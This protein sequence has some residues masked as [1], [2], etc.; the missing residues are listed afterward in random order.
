MQMMNERNFGE[1]VSGYL[2]EYMKDVESAHGTESREYLALKRQFVFDPREEIVDY[3]TERRRH[4]EAE[5]H[6]E[7]EGGPLRGLE[8][9]YQK[10][11]LIEPTTHCLAYCRWCLRAKYPDAKLTREELLRA[12]RYCG[13][14]VNRADVREIL[15]T[16][17]DPLIESDTIG[18]MLDAIAEFAPNVEAVRIGSRLPIH[19]PR[20]VDDGLLEAL[21]PRGKFRVEMGTQINHAVELGK[22]TCSAYERIQSLGI[23][24]YNQ[25]VLLR[26]VNDDIDS[27]CD[28]YN[29]LRSLAIEAHY[30]FHCIPMRGMSHHRTTLE[31]G[32]E[33]VKELVMCG[34][35]SGRAKPMY[36]AMTDVGKVILYD[37]VILDRKGDMVL[38]QTGYSNEER[39]R[40][41]PSW[42]LPDSAY[43]GEDEKIR[44]WYQDAKVHN[45]GWPTTC[46]ID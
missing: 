44:V 22:E 6:I 39:S 19:D 43:V 29:A 4:Y 27:L 42:R 25:Q 2:R 1:R 26:G 20:R 24:V 38:L 3:E 7:F 5:I 14:A 33:L 12:V 31:R 35:I 18:F 46:I 8:R 40:W 23:R 21:R 15:I 13:S 28:L 11:V 30:M 41:N 37:G 10:V 45:E 16:G 17:G 9:L 36:A 34:R 32:L